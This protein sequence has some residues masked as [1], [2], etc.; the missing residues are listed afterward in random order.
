M[1]FMV[2]W[3]LNL[4]IQMTAF[5]ILN[6]WSVSTIKNVF[7]RVLSGAALPL[8]FMPPFIMKIIQFTPFDA[9][10][11]IPLQIYLSK[12]GFTDIAFALAKQIIW[13]AV[14]YSA[15][16]LMWRAGSKKILIQGG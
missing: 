13:F 15:S 4:I 3:S 16:L 2:L 14:F 12:I 11:Y 8:W 9:I 6:V 5:W 7:V 10:Y 1:G